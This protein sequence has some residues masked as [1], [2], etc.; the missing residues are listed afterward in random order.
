MQFIMSAK[1][2]YNYGYKLWLDTSKNRYYMHLR[3]SR[4]H[5]MRSNISHLV[6]GVHGLHVKF[7]TLHCSSGTASVYL[8]EGSFF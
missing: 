7:C 1:C 3:P 4:P 2:V 6:Y 8:L 5:K